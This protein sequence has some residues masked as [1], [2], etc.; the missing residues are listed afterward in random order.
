MAELALVQWGLA[1]DV[2]RQRT[3]HYPASLE[4]ARKLVGGE[5]PSDPFTGGELIYRR[6][7]NGYLL[8]SV[9]ENRRDD[10]GR[11]RELHWDPARQGR[12]RLQA[13]GDSAPR[14]WRDDR[15]ADS[16]IV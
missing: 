10:G 5:L 2:C 7:D 11:D 9:G 1:L 6:R 13:H 15:G 4:E 16:G 3:G 12:N 14:P 8:Y